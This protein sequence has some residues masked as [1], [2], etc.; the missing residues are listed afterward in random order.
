MLVN[1]N[2]LNESLDKKYLTES[3]DLNETFSDMPKW[4]K[5]RILTVKRMDQY[6]LTPH[7]VGK[8]NMANVGPSTT[9]SGRGYQYSGDRYNKSLFKTLLDKGINLD[10]VEVIEG[11]MPA[12][13][14][15]PRIKEP[16]I[17][18]YLFDNGQVYV[19]GCNDSE[20]YRDFIDKD[21]FKNSRAFK[22]LPFKY[23]K[24]NAVKFAY[25]DGSKDSNFLGSER[26][27]E[28]NER[29]SELRGL[30]NYERDR[31]NAGTHDWRMDVDKSGYTVIPSAEKYKDKL[32][33]LKADK[34]FDQLDEFHDYI[35]QAK[36]E[37]SYYFS[38]LDINDSNFRSNNE[39][40]FRDL[41]VTLSDAI[42]EYKEIMSEVD[43]AVNNEDW[44]KDQVRK[45]LG[46]HVIGGYTWE[47]LEGNIK[48]LKRDSGRVFNSVID[49]I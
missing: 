6:G 5:D 41:W 26:R 9:Y 27:K 4:L 36:E 37:L 42:N 25:I 49:W 21:G 7:Q 19:E 29:N 15:D 22:Y 18:I 39:N 46:R 20:E 11:P 43:S 14:T 28:R 3:E 30:V 40:V 34:L 1:L 12:K 45:Y 13:N 32:N 17:P 8:G 44:D 16:N 24:E 10:T 35:M 31:K 2:K 33:E 48:K 23:K 38:N 47:R